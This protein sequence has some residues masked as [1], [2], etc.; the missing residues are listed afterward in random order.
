MRAPILAVALCVLAAC[1]AACGADPT[2]ER[3]VRPADAGVEADVTD[4]RTPDVD[5][6]LG[7]PCTEDGQCDDAIVCTFDRCDQTLSRC[8]NVPDDTQ[9]ADDSYCNGRETCVLRRGCAP[10]S[11]VTCQDDDP[12]TMDRCDEPK[13]ACEHAPRDMDGDGDPDDHCAAKRDC[14][15]AD[16]NIHSQHSEICGNFED[17]DCDGDV[18]EAA[19]T[20]PAN[21]V[22]ATALAVSGTGTY[23]LSTVAAR[24]DYATTCS[25][26]TPSAARDVVVNITVPGASG[27]PPKDVEVWAKAHDPSNELAVAM[28]SVCGQAVTERTCAHIHQSPSARAIV[29]GAEA[30]SVISALI[31][32]QREGAV[33]LDVE[34]RDVATV[35]SNESCASPEAVAID[36]PF[37]VAIIDPIKDLPSACDKAKTGE[38]TYSFTLPER[39]DVRIF[40]STLRGGGAPVVSLRDAT[41]TGE[42]RCR[43]ASSGPLFARNLEAGPHVFTVAGTEQLDA[44]I[45]VKTYPATVAP[46]N[47]NCATAPPI[48]VNTTV[49]VDLTA[50]EDAINNGCLPGGSAAAYDLTLAEASDVLV[51]GRFAQNDVGAVSL[52]RVGCTSADVLECTAGATP[53]RVTKRNL[54]AGSYRVVVA[55]ELGLP[56]QVSVLVRRTVPPTAI[57]ASDGCVS[58]FTLPIGGGFFTGDTSASA[59]DFSAGCDGPGQPIGGAADQLM[60]LVLPDSRRVV[61]DMSGSSY[62]TVLDVR[63]GASCPGLEVPNACYAG[64]NPNR[65]F[66]DLPLAAGTYFV[67]VDGFT[68]EKG[69]WN[70]DVRILAP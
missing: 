66:L 53:A 54:P 59:A 20:Q 43:V 40:G 50:Q 8:R 64:L 45:L 60:K 38:R 47:Q 23:S 48:A 51:I 63:T 49:A 4:E 9:C 17:D 25:V 19:C 16:P 2:P 27:D 28:Q 29:R 33:D 58:P 18:D 52:N 62:T 13:K 5:P 36:V 15:D 30:G 3:F 56:A 22:C 7:G 69:P 6:T 35:P 14:N 68:G 11:V 34:I 37:T 41:C 10:G 12:C 70:L 67:Q 32:S 44:S 46:A 21:D 42:V 55:D 31:V 26:T 61:L 1:P 39:Q 24:P 65:S 57:G